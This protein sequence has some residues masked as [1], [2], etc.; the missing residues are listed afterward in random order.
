MESKKAPSGDRH[1]GFLDTIR[2]FLAFWVYYGHL[3]MAAIGKDVLWGSPAIAVDGFML[4]S[5]FLMAYH[6]VNREIRF[7][8]FW[9][10]AKDFYIRRFF[11]IAPLYYFSL[12]IALFWQDRFE[13]IKNSVFNIVPPDWW[14]AVIVLDN[15]DFQTTTL[16]NI[17]SHYS[18]AFGLIPKYVNSNIL[19]D[20]SIGLEM[21]FYLLFPFLTLFLARFGS[22]T[23]TFVVFL[24][25][26]IA[27]K[28]IGLYDHVGLIA[29]YPQPSL[30]LFKLN[31]FLVGMTIAFAYLSKDQKT[32]GSWL[33]LGLLSLFNAKIQV[34]IIFAIMVLMLF[35]DEDSKDFMA[36]V[37]SWKISKFVGETSY[38]LYLIHLM[39]LF[40]ILHFLFQK[41][42]F[43]NLSIYPRLL[44]SLVIISPLAYG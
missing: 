21:Q 34:F 32:K 6:W 39:V 23:T 20:W 31:I 14:G 13:T 16:G 9:A 40:P 12:T 7:S 3:K 30:I 15:P 35:F 4:L 41:D 36:K 25:T 5:G 17:L 10:Q 29:R 1:I 18:F 44:V 38:G 8:S 24:T 11:R 27:N 28:F 42:W 33:I 26:I 22:I 2:G 37:G 43:L 19:P